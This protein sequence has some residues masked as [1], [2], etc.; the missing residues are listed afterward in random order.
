MVLAYALILWNLI[1]Q[2]NV[3]RLCK[4]LFIYDFIQTI[5][6]VHILAWLGSLYFGPQTWQIDFRLFR[7]DKCNIVS[8]ATYFRICR[9]SNN[10]LN[11]FDWTLKHQSFCPWKYY[12]YFS[13]CKSPTS[14]KT[15]LKSL[16][17]CETSL[18][19]HFCIKGLSFELHLL[20]SLWELCY[21]E[22]RTPGCT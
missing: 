14:F 18:A 4:L 8:T 3:S 16:H 13:L 10:Y 6:T 9:N 5:L 20:W 11:I 17:F 1:E 21:L 22:P 2:R 7:K 15:E 19:R 12:L